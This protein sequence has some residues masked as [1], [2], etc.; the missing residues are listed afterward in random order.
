MGRD[1][2]C[3]SKEC[4]DK[5]PNCVKC[6]EGKDHQ[7]GCCDDCGEEMCGVC[8]YNACS[9]DPNAACPGCIKIVV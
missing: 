1:D 5:D 3:Q 8:R 7:V 6:F 4:N 2:N 9:K